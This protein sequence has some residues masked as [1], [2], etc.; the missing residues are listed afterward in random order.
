MSFGSIE[1]I[2]DYAIAREKEAVEFYESISERES[3]AATKKTLKE[4]AGEERKHQKMLEDFSADK[5]KLAG[6]KYEWIPDIK[7]SD[8]MV[9]IEYREGMNYPELLR[10]AM[11]REEMA[12]KM[13][14]NLAGK[15]D[16]DACIKLFKVLCQEEAKHKSILETIYDDHMAAQ[17]D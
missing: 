1:E 9:D 15:T 14:Q 5:D 17:G 11:K 7:R 13:Y 16:D 6:Y 4:F 12:L 3:F 2:I 8:Y 10:L